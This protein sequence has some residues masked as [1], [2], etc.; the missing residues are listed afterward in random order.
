MSSMMFMSFFS[1]KEIKVFE[2]K[3]YRIYIYIYTV[4]AVKISTLTQAII[5]FS[6]KR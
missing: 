4:S 3:Q 5:F 1:H 2:D 6:L